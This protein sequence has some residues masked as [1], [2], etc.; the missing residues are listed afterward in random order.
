MYEA[1]F[2]SECMQ[3]ILEASLKIARVAIV[4]G[5]YKRDIIKLSF[6]TLSIIIGRSYLINLSRHLFSKITFQGRMLVINVL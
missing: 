3:K 6:L 1:S 4:I 5:K 2:Q